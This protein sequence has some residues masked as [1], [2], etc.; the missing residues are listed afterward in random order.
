[1]SFDGFKNCYMM[2]PIDCWEGSIYV[3]DLFGMYANDIRAY[4]TEEVIDI[5]GEEPYII[6]CGI[7][8][9]P[10]SFSF[11][12]VVYAK[13]SNNGTTYAFTDAELHNS[14]ITKEKTNAEA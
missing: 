7:I 11:K 5:S 8:A 3:E 10:D 9:D 6:R 12:P 2:P 13:I 4:V 14:D 1:M